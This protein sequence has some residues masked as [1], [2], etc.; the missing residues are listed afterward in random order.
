MRTDVCITFDVEFTIG[1]AFADPNEKQPVGERSVLCEVNGKSQGLGFILE[2]LDTH[3][4]SATFFVEAL[5]TSFFGDAPMQRIAN[6]ILAAGHDVQLHLHPCWQYFRQ[7]DWRERLAT[8]PPNDSMA[9]RSDNE[10]ET[11]ISEG[12]AA[13]GRWGLPR[14]I[15]LR[16]GGLQVDLAVYSAMARLD[17]PLASNVGL[18]VWRPRE[19]ELQLYAGRHLLSGILEVPTLSYRDI[20]VPGYDH[21]KTLTIT[22]S[23]WG[24]VHWLL[25]Q[26]HRKRAGPV[27]ILSHPSEFIKHQDVQYTRLRSNRLNQSRFRRLCRFLAA[28]E[29]D[30]NTVTFADSQQRWRNDAETGN[31]CLSVPLSKTM[32]RLAENALN[33]AT[34]W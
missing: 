4:L 14:P 13:F 3:G 18:A 15:A 2:T 9:S 31:T 1:G 20:D 24:E 11:L 16:T 7:Q 23:S 21:L 17:I 30:F 22:G 19:T 8:Q 10:L 32:K 28:H 5:N 33:D 26:A 27:V 29:D 25:K 6:Q 12:I 34:P